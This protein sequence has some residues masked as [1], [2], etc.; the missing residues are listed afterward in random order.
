M[1][2]EEAQRWPSVARGS[3]GDLDGLSLGAWVTGLVARRS[4][5]DFDGASLIAG[6]SVVRC[7]SWDWRLGR[8]TLGRERGV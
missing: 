2:E 8:E 5:G 7:S 1:A 3:S 4:S 6:V